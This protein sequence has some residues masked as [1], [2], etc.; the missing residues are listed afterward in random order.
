MGCW[1]DELTVYGLLRDLFIAS[2]VTCFLWAMHRIGTGVMLAGR[3][4]ALAEHGEAY[5]P[6]E[7]E[8]LVHK[9]TTSAMRY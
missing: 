3:I 2:S 8:A 4:A 9:I 1:D 6:E 7:R 5:T